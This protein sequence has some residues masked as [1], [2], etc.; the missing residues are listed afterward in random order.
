MFPQIAAALGIDAGQITLMHRGKRVDP[1]QP[2]SMS[3]LMNNSEVEVVL[4]SNVLQMW[5]INPRHMHVADF[6]GYLKDC[7]V[8]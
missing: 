8:S 1:S 7:S 5:Y 4:K 2:F 6:L 3:G